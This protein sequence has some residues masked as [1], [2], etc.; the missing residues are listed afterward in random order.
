M[1]AYNYEKINNLIQPLMKMLQ[2]EYPNGYRLI[3]EPNFARIQHIS[4]ELIFSK[5]ID[6]AEIKESA[7]SFLETLFNVLFENQKDNKNLDKT[8]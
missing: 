6:E 7:N 3:I 1:K 2:E 4:D 5:Q 8:K